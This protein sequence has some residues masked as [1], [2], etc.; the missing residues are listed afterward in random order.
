MEGCRRADG[1]Q[2]TNLEDWI[3][4]AFSGQVVSRVD[5]VDTVEAR[6]TAPE[7]DTIF[8]RMRLSERR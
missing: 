8:Y 3:P 2:S 7:N 1:K 4:I 6:V 5:E